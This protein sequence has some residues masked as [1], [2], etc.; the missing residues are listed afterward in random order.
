V[1]TRNRVIAIVKVEVSFDRGVWESQPPQQFDD[2][3]DAPVLIDRLRRDL[4]D[5]SLEHVFNLLALSLDRGSLSIAFKALHG[6][7]ARLR[8]TALEYLETV[9]PDE[10]RDAVWPYLGE[11]R[12]M[13]RARAV[14][15]ILADLEHSAART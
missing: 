12:P 1:I 8:G 2:D 7:D 10:V 13:R 11:E 9:L 3:A 14:A 4:L 15:E 5:R 6:A